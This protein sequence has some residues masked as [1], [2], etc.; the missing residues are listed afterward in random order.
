MKQKIYR[1]FLKSLLTFSFLSISLGTMSQNKT[2]Y[3]TVT[4]ELGL[5]LPGVSILQKRTNNGVVTDFDGNYQI[6][7]IS[8]EQTLVF[9]YMGFKS[10]EAKVVKQTNIN[11]SLKESLQNLDE[12]VLVGY[13]RQKRSDLTGSIG[14]IKSDE[15][16]DIQ[17]P[18]VTQALQGRISGVQITESSGEPGAAISIQIRGV[19]TLGND[20]EPLYVIDGIPLS[21]GGEAEG[22]EFATGSNPL[23]SLNPNDIESIDVLKD[24]SAASIYGSRAS[25][26][27]II[28]TTK[29]GSSGVLRVNIS[30]R[31]YIQ[32][33]R[34]GDPLMNGI[35][36]AQARNEQE[37]LKF[38]TLS[39]QEL[40]DQELIPYRGESG[41]FRPLPENAG[42]GTNWLESVLRQAEGQNYQVGISGGSNNVKHN[43]SSNYDNQEGTII[44]SKFE[45]FNMRYNLVYDLKDNIKLTTSTNFN[46]IRNERAK[47]GTRTATQ[48]VI[49]W[50]RRIDPNIPLRDE[51]GGITETDEFGNFIVNPYIEA[52]EVDDVSK[53]VDWSFASKLLWKIDSKLNFNLNFGLDQR[54]SDRTIFHPFST[55]V[56]RNA[57][58]RFLGS[59]LNHKH[60]STEAFL[61]YNNKFKK[62]KLNIVGG[63][64]FENFDTFRDRYIISNFTFD[65]LGI[66]AIQLGQDR[67]SATSY[68]EVSTLQSAFSRINYNFDNKYLVTLS[69]RTDGSSKFAEGNKWSFFPALAVA[70]NVNNESFLKDSEFLDQLKLRYTIGQTGNQAIGAYSTLAQFLIGSS[71]FADSE[72]YTSTYPGNIANL[73]LKWS[74]TTQSN[75]GL[76]FGF[77]DGLFRI[78][79]DYY[80][81]NTDDLLLNQSIAPSNGFNTVAT[82]FGSIENKGF[83]VSLKIAA[84]NKSNFSW[85]TNIN[86]SK[87]K[88]TITS[89]GDNEFIDGDNISANFLNFPGNRTFVG[90]EPGLFYGWIVD[91]LIQ[92]DDLTDYAN[93]DLNI[94]NDVDGN[95]V[96]VA[97]NGVT[98]PGQWKY[99][100]Q[101]TID[102]DGDGIFDKADGVINGDDRQVIGNPNPDFTFGWNN[103]FKF[104]KRFSASLFFQGSYG[105]D[106]LNASG[107]YT[108]FGFT[109]YNSTEEWFNKRWTLNNQHN[110][111]KYPSGI[112]N[113]RPTNISV[114]DG[115]FIRLKN[116][117]LRYSIPVEKK[118]DINKL[119][120]VL[121][122]TN[123]FTLT[124][125]SGAD[126]EVSS[127]GTS[128]LQAGIDYN[129]YPR[130]RVFSLGLN[131]NF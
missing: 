130:S 102:T 120:L 5:P 116:V 94:R 24:A 46:S 38:P 123:I 67:S 78:T 63:V 95:P 11:I 7:L 27:V 65:N 16:E 88:T 104:G 34:I 4:S 9:S 32:D 107:V 15:L 66:D 125:Y 86:F 13:G 55:T 103:E 57:V 42:I 93:G 90:G 53:N 35:E 50:A 33:F 10:Q 70:W 99:A 22:E 80:I 129:A 62:H 54:K 2:V 77:G 101:L 68:R 71:V 19:N 58:G 30:T 124:N 106:I 131:L 31:S 82:N 52:T 21:Y 112:D 17:F 37:A 91:G 59:N 40:I 23:A 76:D 51:L 128:P 126:P 127:F 84:V 26:G 69:G 109:N 39:F 36:I 8:G 115:S 96:F 110:N 83:E 1:L 75:F 105:N 121:S 87:N 18:S 108:N 28:I 48:G 3:G 122:G 114:E 111:P 61:D 45:R 44:H 29:K 20:T 118:L 74:T 72:F 12:I 89:L 64:A 85:D 6:T 41:S 14:S 25:N 81:K 60:Y 97:D 56:G 47:T 98:T 43:F 100:D 113:V 73:D 79:T 49:N 117:V 119:E 92:T